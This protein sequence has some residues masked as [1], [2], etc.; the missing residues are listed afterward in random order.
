MKVTRDPRCSAHWAYDAL[1]TI[2][3]GPR[4]AWS[5][6]VCGRHLGLASIV[7]APTWPLRPR[8]RPRRLAPWLARLGATDFG[9]VFPDEDDQ[10]SED[11]GGDT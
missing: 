8:R 1:L 5:C 11:D 7:L 9:W 4:W 6:S 3:N 2:M 10:T